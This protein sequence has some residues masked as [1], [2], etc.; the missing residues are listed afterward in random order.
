MGNVFKDEMPPIPREAPE[1]RPEPF[2]WQLVDG[3]E[4]WTDNSAVIANLS[5]PPII[6]GLLREGEVASVVGGAKSCKTWFSLALA[7]AVATGEPFLV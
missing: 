6:E 5:D 7:L 1:A 2:S 4:V 3:A